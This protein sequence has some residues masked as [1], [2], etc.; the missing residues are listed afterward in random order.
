MGA[1]GYRKLAADLLS[2]AVSKLETPPPP[3]EPPVPPVGER[4]Y[5]KKRRGQ[6]P[7]WVTRAEWV[8]EL[9]REWVR[10]WEEW[11]E[12]RMRERA[13]FLSAERSEMWCD[14][15]GVDREVIVERLR[16]DNLL[17]DA[18]TRFPRNENG[19]CTLYE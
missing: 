18:A 14:A 3:D 15:A 1:H 12:S 16:A 17:Y 9:R 2:D 19:L 10:K 6:D 5:W 8:D 13:F 11:E 7:V 4:G